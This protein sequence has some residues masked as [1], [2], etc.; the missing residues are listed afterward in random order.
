MNKQ[1]TISEMSKRFA[2]QMQKGNINGAIKL[3]TNNM[4][5]GIL[6]LKKETMP[7]LK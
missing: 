3:L 5:I 2:E 4:Q 7:L 1:R 6:P